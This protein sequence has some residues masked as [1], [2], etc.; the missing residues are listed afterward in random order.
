MKTICMRRNGFSLGS[1]MNKTD[2][3]FTEDKFEKNLMER[4][5]KNKNMFLQY[6]FTYANMNMKTYA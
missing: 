3:A 5:E 4:K 2:G 1:Q 6:T